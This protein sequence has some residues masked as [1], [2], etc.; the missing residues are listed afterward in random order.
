[1]SNSRRD[2]SLRQGTGRFVEQDDAGIAGKGSS[3]F[4]EL[5]C[6]DRLTSHDCF[7][8]QVV[9][10]NGVESLTHT[11]ALSRSKERTAA[12]AHLAEQ[13]VVFDTQ[14]GREVQLLVDHGNAACQGIAGTLRLKRPTVDLH[15][16][17]VSTVSTAE[18]LEQRAFAGTVLADQ[19]QDSAGVDGQ[20]HILQRTGR[21]KPLTDS[22]HVK[23]NVVH[24]QHSSDSG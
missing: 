7:R 10:A 18:R 16:A 24:E 12:R 13:H 2:I 1:M 4:E 19:S 17:C 8:I 23:Q 14:V 20:R 22:L 15:R 11:V 21:P 6:G 3:D 5:L 9:Q